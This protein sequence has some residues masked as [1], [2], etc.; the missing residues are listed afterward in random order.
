MVSLR[1]ADSPAL[2]ED[3]SLRLPV[4]LARRAAKPPKKQDDQPDRKPTRARPRQGNARQGTA[5]PTPATQKHK[6]SR[7]STRTNATR[8]TRTHTPKHPERQPET[9]R[10]P[11]NRS[12]K[13]TY[14]VNRLAESFCNG[15]SR[16][17]LQT[18]SGGRGPDRSAAAVMLPR[19]E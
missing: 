12:P 11:Q 9:E 3:E 17:P 4:C 7:T 6:R 5:T 10:K 2:F 13:K 15:R 1:V 19:S 18:R 14:G 8:H 16:S